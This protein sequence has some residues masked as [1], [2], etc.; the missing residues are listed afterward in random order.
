MKQTGVAIPKG[1]ETAN[2]D[3]GW[4]VSFR[5]LNEIRRV[6]LENTMHTCSVTEEHIEE[7]VMALCKKGHV[8]LG[9]RNEG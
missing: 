3:V 6:I 7:V 5:F 2:E 9:S 1:D 4:L 8:R